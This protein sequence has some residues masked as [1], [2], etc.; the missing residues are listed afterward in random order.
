[1]KD[2]KENK[3]IETTGI[4][5]GKDELHLDTR[6]PFDENSKVKVII[7]PYESIDT[8]E[9]TEEE[10]LKFASQNPA[11]TDLANPDEDIYTLNDGEPFNG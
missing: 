6:L 8:G 5:N 3:I 2:K 9:I 1:M 11:F 10:W 7:M 4:V